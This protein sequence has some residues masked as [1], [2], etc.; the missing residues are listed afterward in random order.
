M[1]AAGL[2]LG[3]AAGVVFDVGWGLGLLLCSVC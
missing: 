3:A 1:K 2:S